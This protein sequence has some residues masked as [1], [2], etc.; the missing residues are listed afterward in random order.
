[1]RP[2]DR[3]TWYEDTENGVAYFD[4]GFKDRLN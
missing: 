1:M 4:K 2:S 3:S